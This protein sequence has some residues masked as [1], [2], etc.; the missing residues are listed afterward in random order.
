MIM[1]THSVY[2]VFNSNYRKRTIKIN[3]MSLCLSITGSFLVHLPKEKAG[4]HFNNLGMLTTLL[5]NSKKVKIKSTGCQP[6]IE[7][8]SSV[9]E[10]GTEDEVFTVEEKQFDWSEKGSCATNG[11][12][13]VHLHFQYCLLY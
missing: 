2:H 9:N 1:Y 6:K 3:K 13:E 12:E 11:N 10:D 8:I 5:G 4:Q 7:V